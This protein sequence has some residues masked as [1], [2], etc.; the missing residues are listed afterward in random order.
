MKNVLIGID[1]GTSTT[2]VIFS[3]IDVENTGGY[4]SVPRV[5]IVD[6]QVIFKSPVYL[7]PL[8]TPILIDGE[9]VRQLVDGAY[10]EAG[11]SPNILYRSSDLE[12]ILTM[13]AAEEGIS[14]VPEYAHAWDVGA[15]NVVF[16][17]LTGKGE[18]E[19]ILVAWRKG[20][21]N[22]ALHHFISKLSE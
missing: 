1:I 11:Y 20:D 7:T 12:V 6:K 4:F 21:Q 3:R 19:E 5:S 14:I 10:R 17:P 22:P 18:T 15:E 16:V 8:K 13:V 2:Q 9:Q